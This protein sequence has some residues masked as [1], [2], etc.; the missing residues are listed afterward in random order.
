MHTSF[1]TFVAGA[2]GGIS[3]GYWLARLPGRA[4]PGQAHSSQPVRLATIAP[5]HP[6]IRRPALYDQDAG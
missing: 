1:V 3:T 4:R 2:I 5:T 6:A